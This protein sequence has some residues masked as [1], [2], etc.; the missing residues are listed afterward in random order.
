MRIGV[1]KAIASFEEDNLGNMLLDN[2]NSLDNTEKG[3]AIETLS[4]RPHYGWQLTTALKN[5]RNS[6]ERY[7]C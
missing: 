7:F 4:S 1:I 3:N 6:K 2:Y 5:K